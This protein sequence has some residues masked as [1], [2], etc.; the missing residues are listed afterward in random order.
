MSAPAAL[1][2]GK[3]IYPEKEHSETAGDVELPD[4]DSGSNVIEAATNGIMDGLKLA[5]NVGASCWSG[6][7]P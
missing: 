1:V 3:I 5:V 7:S 4:I 2:I 6:S